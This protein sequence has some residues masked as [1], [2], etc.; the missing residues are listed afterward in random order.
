MSNSNILLVDDVDLV[1]KPT[2]SFLKR[3]FNVFTASNGIEAW[4]I[5]SAQGVDCLITDVNMPIMNGIELLKK[6]KE[7]NCDIKT[8]VVSGTYDLSAKEEFTG[9]EVD[10]Y[11][12]KP[13]RPSDLIKKVKTLLE[14]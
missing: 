4:N 5:L 14:R 11:F 1:L 8:I 6:M 12:T 3:E 13:Y 2:A 10:A 9:L 7:N